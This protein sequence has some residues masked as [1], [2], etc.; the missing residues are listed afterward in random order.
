VTGPFETEREAAGAAHQLVP[1]EDGRSILGADQNR[2]LL[3]GACEA[4]GVELGAYDRR[5][6]D[7]LAGYEDAMCA[8]VAGLISRAAHRP[9]PT[10]GEL[11]AEFPGWAIARGGPGEV[12]ASRGQASLT[13]EDWAGLR[14]QISR[15]QDRHPE[16]ASS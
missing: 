2:R 1:P 9:E 5:I 14:E 11:W 7:W 4:A 3:V 12:Y 13:G 8:V 6:L 15:W 16:G 10:L